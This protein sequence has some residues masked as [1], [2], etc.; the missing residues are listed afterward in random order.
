VHTLDILFTIIGAKYGGGDLSVAQG[1][2]M[3]R[4][5]RWRARYV[6]PGLNV[7]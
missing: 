7:S 4:Q 2:L 1:A 5:T 3:T 6:L